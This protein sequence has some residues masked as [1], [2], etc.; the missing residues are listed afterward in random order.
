MIDDGAD[1][2]RQLLRPWWIRGEL[3]IAEGEGSHRNDVAEP[4]D[5]DE[6]VVISQ[7][8]R[9]RVHACSSTSSSSTSFNNCCATQAPTGPSPPARYQALWACK[10]LTPVRVPP[11]PPCGRGPV[12]SG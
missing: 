2:V 9:H 10:P 11:T 6:R 1:G 5:V 7:S 12:W 4:V 3:G 8:D